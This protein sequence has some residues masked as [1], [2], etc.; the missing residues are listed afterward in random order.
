MRGSSLTTHAKRRIGERCGL[1]Q[2]ELRQILD[3][4]A[5]IPIH[6]Q[7]GGRYVHWLIY[8]YRDEDWFMV[9]QDGGDG[10]VLTVMPLEYLKGRTEVR[11]AHKRQARRKAIDVRDRVAVPTA[12]AAVPVPETVMSTSTSVAGARRWRLR[13]RYKAGGKVGFKMLPWVPVEFGNPTDWM[14]EGPIHQWIKERLIEA[15][16]PFGGIE[17][18]LAVGKKQEIH[19]IDDLLQH[20]PL[21]EAEI[22]SCR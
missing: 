20:L 22:N 15:E 21:T 10:G 5:G 4:S 16:I 19:S 3:A 12:R 13:V 7:K 9:V 17:S 1:S 6:L 8:S 14:I 11:A 18:V 2:V